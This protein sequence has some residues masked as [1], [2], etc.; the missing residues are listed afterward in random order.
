MLTTPPRR[1]QKGRPSAPTASQTIQVPKKFHAK[2]AQGGRFF[3]SLPSG[4][5]VT[6]AG[7]KPPSSTIKSK[8]PPTAASN[9]AEAPSGRIDDGEQPSE[10]S[11]VEF[12]LVALYDESEEADDEE[13]PWVVQSASEEDAQRVIKEIEKSLELAKSATHTAW[14]TVPRGLSE[15]RFVR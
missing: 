1:L 11:A 9:G 8:K 12:Q 2:I 10:D 3:R 15:C 6:H 13:I 7:Q 4:T 14:L 5:R